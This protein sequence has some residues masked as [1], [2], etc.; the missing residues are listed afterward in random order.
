MAVDSASAGEATPPFSSAYSAQLP[1]P[2]APA[3]P[4]D[5]RFAAHPGY[6]APPPPYNSAAAAF[7]PP[8]PPYGSAPPLPPYPPPGSAPAPPPP[9]APAPAPPVL[10]PGGGAALVAAAA[11]VVDEYDPARPND[12]EKILRERKRKAAEE[13]RRR[14]MERR[15]KEEEER[16]KER[17]AVLQRQRDLELAIKAERERAAAAKAAE[18]EGG[19]SASPA[20]AAASAGPDRSQLRVSGEEAW[21]RRAMLSGGGAGG[22]AGGGLGAAAGGASASPRA[23]ERSPSPPKSEGF[24]MPKNSGDGLTAAE[25]MMMKMGWK[26]GQ[27]LGKQEQGITTPLMA[28]KTD[29]HGGVIVAAKPLKKGSGGEG[30]ENNAAGAGG[31]RAKLGGVALNGPPSK[32]VLLRNMVGPGEVDEELE[33]EVAG[34]CLKYGTVT[35]VLI[36]EITDPSCRPVEAVRIFITFDRPESATKALVD[37]DGR[38]F[39]GRT[40]RACFFDEEKFKKNDLAPGPNEPPVPDF[41]KA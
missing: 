30:A 40:V 32:V 10:P 9:P 3:Y 8:V 21:R 33:E 22:G 38:F 1:P 4:P 24:A 35:R 41:Q 25:R 2:H 13:E 28:K 15:R 12:Y 36:F 17:E 31:K 14:E 26:A 20:A 29:K 37:L 18:Q 7:P 39:G 6:Q 5:P 23:A 11:A 34:E 19:A 27:G 16:E